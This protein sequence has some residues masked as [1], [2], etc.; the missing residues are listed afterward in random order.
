M[1]TSKDDQRTAKK[2]VDEGSD[3]TT[4]KVQRMLY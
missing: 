4:P 2:I 1:Y 3:Q